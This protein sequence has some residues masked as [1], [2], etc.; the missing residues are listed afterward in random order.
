MKTY[1]KK[2]SK[3][4]VLHIAQLAH[5]NL[6]DG[7]IE[8]FQSQLSKII[9]YISKLKEVDTEGV[10]PTNQVT[11]LTNKTREDK[12]KPADSLTPQEALQNASRK[13]GSFFQVNA[14]FEEE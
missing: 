7:E 1:K 6:S 5:L 2:L 8:K 13:N 10:I 12:V 9:A 3:E 14:L 4:D 11:G